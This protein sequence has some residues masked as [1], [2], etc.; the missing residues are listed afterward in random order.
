MGQNYEIRGIFC[1][2]YYFLF[3]LFSPGLPLAASTLHGAN[4]TIFDPGIRKAE[5]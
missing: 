2:F 1:L 5:A 3:S 4:L